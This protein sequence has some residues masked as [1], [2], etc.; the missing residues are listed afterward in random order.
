MKIQKTITFYVLLF[1]F[2]LLS[3]CFMKYL[4]VREGMYTG[5]KFTSKDGNTEVKINADTDQ[6]KK[7]INNVKGQSSGQSSEQSSNETDHGKN[8]TVYDF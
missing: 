8:V 5:L 2:C 1:I 4:N 7:F 3:F 6:Y